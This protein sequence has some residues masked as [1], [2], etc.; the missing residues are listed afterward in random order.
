MMSKLRRALYII[1]Y[2]Y[3]TDLSDGKNP[4][5]KCNLKNYEP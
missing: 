1:L 3:V 2:I 5:I 4:I